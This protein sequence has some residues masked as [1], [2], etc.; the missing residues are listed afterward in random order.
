MGRGRVR[1][2]GK[3]A[4]WDCEPCGVVSTCGVDSGVMEKRANLACRLRDARG[5][6]MGDNSSGDRGPVYWQLS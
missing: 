2:L 6:W 1:R 5:E 4:V 3:G